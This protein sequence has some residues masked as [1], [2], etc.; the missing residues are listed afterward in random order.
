MQL[1]G[2]HDVCNVSR[3]EDRDEIRT[4]HDECFVPHVWWKN[5][6]PHTTTGP[7]HPSK[8]FETEKLEEAI[9][10]IGTRVNEEVRAQTNND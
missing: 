10:A 2:K 6:T 8:S 1:I 5:V 3:R 7:P 4:Y 9:L